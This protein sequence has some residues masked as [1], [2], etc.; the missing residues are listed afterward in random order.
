MVLSNQ[1]KYEYN[2]HNEPTEEE[3]GGKLPD[4]QSRTSMKYTK[5]GRDAFGVA[6]YSYMERSS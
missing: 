4:E 5:E 3:F 6:K 2:Q 1:S